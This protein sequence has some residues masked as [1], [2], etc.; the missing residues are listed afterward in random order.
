M[1]KIKP[2]PGFPTPK[3]PKRNTHANI[4]MSITFLIPK[5]FKK[6]GIARIHNASQICEIEINMLECCTAK[7]EEYSCI[8]S[9]L[10]KNGLA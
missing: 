1:K 10:P 9:K 6:N 5:R 8:A 4:A 2:L 7:V 3:K